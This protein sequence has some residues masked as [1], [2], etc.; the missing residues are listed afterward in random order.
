MKKYALTLQQLLKSL[1][2]NELILFPKSSIREQV[3]L[4]EDRLRV[5]GAVWVRMFG[6]KCSYEKSQEMFRLG[7]ASNTLC[8]LSISGWSRNS[9]V[10]GL[11]GGSTLIKRI[12]LREL[13]CLHHL[14]W[15]GEKEWEKSA[16]LYLYLPDRCHLCWPFKTETLQLSHQRY[17]FWGH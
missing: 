13:F 3:Q 2:I 1:G 9:V 17:C 12:F 14:Q 16:L 11:P 5:T 10:T 6:P 8:L 7:T 15:K 4:E